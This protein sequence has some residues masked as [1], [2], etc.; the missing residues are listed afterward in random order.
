MKNTVK[1]QS[2]LALIFVDKIELPYMVIFPVT[3]LC[4]FCAKNAYQNV[5]NSIT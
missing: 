3:L 5:T 2:L 1:R 4:H